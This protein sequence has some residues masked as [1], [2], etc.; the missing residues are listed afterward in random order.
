MRSES[1]ARIVA[2]AIEQYSEGKT[3][4]FSPAVAFGRGTLVIRQLSLGNLRFGS[5]AWIE[6]M[7]FSVSLEFP[8]P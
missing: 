8:R 7:E 2:R 3:G 6:A 1:D 5:K 4:S